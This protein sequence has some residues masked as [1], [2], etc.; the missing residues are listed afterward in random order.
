M[1]A[2]RKFLISALLST[3]ILTNSITA[4]GVECSGGK[5]RIN[6]KTFN[7][8]RNMPKEI[9]PFKNVQKKHRFLISHSD[10]E[11]Q[12]RYEDKQ[13]DTFSLD[14]KKYTRQQH[15]L[16]QPLT[17]EE[18]NTIILAPEKYVGNDE[19]REKYYQQQREMGVELELIELTLPMSLY[20][21]KN[22][23]EP[24]YD[25]KLEQFQCIISS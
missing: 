10:E 24:I 17:E 3:I 21:C 6:V 4:Q 19:E 20:Y 14:S 23:S 8:S 25:E 22:D 16:L 7:P 5:C 12:V 1:L 18:L 15:E 13:L 2:K 9:K 11:L